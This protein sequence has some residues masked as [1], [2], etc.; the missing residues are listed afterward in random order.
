M[1]YNVISL[2]YDRNFA[3]QVEY[4]SNNPGKFKAGFCCVPAF[5]R[6][7]YIF[8][9]PFNILRESKKGININRNVVFISNIA[10]S[11]FV[12]SVPVNST[13]AGLYEFIKK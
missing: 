11:N 13:Y 1:S 10:K 6:Q 3:F 2:Y 5:N 8:T 12:F 7:V 4:T 9:M